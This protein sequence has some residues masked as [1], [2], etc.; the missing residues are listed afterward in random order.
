[1]SKEGILKEANKYLQDKVRNAKLVRHI[2]F[3]YSNIIEKKNCNL[4]F[5]I[6]YL[7]IN[8]FIRN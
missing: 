3:E 1:M 6:Y 7:I 5:L 4:D 8:L 2:H